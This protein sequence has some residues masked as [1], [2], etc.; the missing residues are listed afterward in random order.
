MRTIRRLVVALVVVVVAWTITASASASGTCHASPTTASD[1]RTDPTSARLVVGAWNAEWLFDGQNDVA[2]SPY[3][4]GNVAGADAHVSDVANVV[5][6]LDADVLVLVE[7]ESCEMLERAAGSGNATTYAAHMVQGTDTFTMQNVGLLTKVDVVSALSRVE[8]RGD[9]DSSTS[10]CAWSGRKDSGV[11]KH[12]LARTRVN[13]RYVSIIGAHLKAFPTD[14]SSC[15]QREAQVEVLRALARARYEAGDAVVVAGD[16]NDFSELHVDSD[17][18][19][20]TSRVLAKLRDFDGD[21]VDELEEA[22]GSR[23]S[24]SDRYTWSS[25]TGS[26]RSKLDYILTSSGDVRVVSASIRHD[27]VTNAISD[28]YP[29]VATIEVLATR[30]E[31]SAKAKGV[32]GPV[33]YV[34][35]ALA[36]V[37]GVGLARKFGACKTKLETK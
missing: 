2:A 34:I 6:A 29:L 16:L 30:D 26:S 13:D 28:H 27:L 33:L 8:D 11:S 17:G 10:T 36:L 21:G 19:S 35:A 1:R 3:S 9:Y 15:A 18:N 23:V 31:A 14:A 12:F 22:V 20:P 4:G 37:V 7:A 5:A 25:S 32:V 24:Q